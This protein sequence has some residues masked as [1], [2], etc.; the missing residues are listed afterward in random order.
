MRSVGFF[1]VS[2]LSLALSMAEA[3]LALAAGP[4]DGTWVLDIPA[5]RNR[6]GDYTTSAYCPALR[7]PVEIR[8]SKVT[9]DLTR[10]P[11]STGTPEIE[12]GK[13]RVSAPVTGTVQADGTVVARWQNYHAAGKL[14]G[15]SGQVTVQG[16]C[17]PRI[18]KATRIK[19]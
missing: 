16:E 8:D 17:G 4:F 2:V 12:A 3:S 15:D 14:V 11:N 19:N 6:P 9:G 18:A 5:S 1:S 7:L 13:S 10:V